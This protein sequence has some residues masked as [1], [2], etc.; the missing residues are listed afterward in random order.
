MN[1]RIIP[2][3][4]NEPAEVLEI[5]PFKHI[6]KLIDNVLPY[7]ERRIVWKETLFIITI[8]TF[9]SVFYYPGQRRA[10]SSR[11]RYCFKLRVIALSSAY[12]QFSSERLYV[13][14]LETSEIAAVSLETFNRVV[15]QQNLWEHFSKLL[16]YTASRVYEHCSQISQMSAY[17]IIRFQLV[18]LMQEPSYP[19]KYHRRGLYQKSNLSFPQRRYAHPRRATNGVNT[20][21]WSAECWLTSTTCRESIDCSC[22]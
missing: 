11:G 6:E 13:R 5:K 7:A 20:L 18:E 22:I 8:M 15:A 10:A 16:I 21:P 9:V 17:D 4:G 14:V 2:E 3:L 19:A 1:T 12:S